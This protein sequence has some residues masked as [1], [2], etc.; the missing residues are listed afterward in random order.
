MVNAHEN[1]LT[2]AQVLEGQSQRFGPL[3]ISHE[4]FETDLKRRTVSGEVKIPV[5]GSETCF[6]TF[7]EGKYRELEARLTSFAGI[8]EGY[9]SAQYLSKLAHVRRMID[10]PSDS[11]MNEEENKIRKIKKYFPPY[12]NADLYRSSKDAR[13]L[14]V[15]FPMDDLVM[16]FASGDYFTYCDARRLKKESGDLKNADIWSKHE[17]QVRKFC[18]RG[19]V[20]IDEKMQVDPAAIAHLKA[21]MHD[22]F[23]IPGDPEERERIIQSLHIRLDQWVKWL[24]KVLGGLAQSRAAMER[25]KFNAADFLDGLGT[26]SQWYLDFTREDQRYV[27]DCCAHHLNANAVYVRGTEMEKKLGILALAEPKYPTLDQFV[28]T[29][30]RSLANVALSG[31]GADVTKVGVLPR[32]VRDEVRSQVVSLVKSRFQRNDSAFND[33]LLQSPKGRLGEVIGISEKWD[34]PDMRN[35][36]DLARQELKDG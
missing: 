6:R 12:R 27:L 15:F 8:Y 36:I 3:L 34:T 1:T 25:N 5:P 30:A 4:Q 17:S 35:A 24:S 10:V 11:W 7:N 26:H 16:E 18:K 33:A 28:T 20:E 32:H 22:R 19:F 9:V 29:S 21:H 23:N 2:D 13:G 31:R 14:N